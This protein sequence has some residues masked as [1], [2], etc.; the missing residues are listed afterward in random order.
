MKLS[1]LQMC[2]WRQTTQMIR[3]VVMCVWSVVILMRSWIL[4]YNIFLSLPAFLL[5]DFDVLSSPLVL[6][7]LTK[8]LEFIS[9]KSPLWMN[10]ETKWH[11]MCILSSSTV[12]VPSSFQLP[13]QRSKTLFFVLVSHHRWQSPMPDIEFSVWFWRIGFINFNFRCLIIITVISGHGNR[14]SS[15]KKR[16]V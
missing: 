3:V 13:W 7:I 9:N 15:V 11:L 14:T 2:V 10:C 8:I 16:R 5:P 4:I 1:I 6:A 12:S